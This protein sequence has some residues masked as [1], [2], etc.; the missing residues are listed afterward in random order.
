MISLLQEF[1]QCSKQFHAPQHRPILQWSFENR[2]ADFTTLEFRATVAFLLD[3]LP[4]HVCGTWHLSKKAAQRDAADRALGFFVGCWGEQ[5]VGQQFVFNNVHDP[6]SVAGAK[7]A[8]AVPEVVMLEDY[9]RGLPACQG[10][11]LHWGLIWENDL[12]RAQVEVHLLGVPHKLAGAFRETREAAQRDAARRVLWYLQCP[13]F[14]DLFEPDP[15]A[16]AVTEREIPAPPTHWV[17]DESDEDT[18][19]VAERK[20]ALMRAQNRLQQA[21]A[22]QLK[23]GQSV[24]EWTYETDSEDAGWP[25]MCRATAHVPVIGKT[26]TGDWARGQRAA[27]IDA[28]V[29]VAAFL[30]E[31]GA[32]LA[33]DETTGSATSN[34]LLGFCDPTYPDSGAAK[35]ASVMCPR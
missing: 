5:E 15:H 32:K 17:G 19:Q 16:P 1:V 14:E 3:G 18:L 6:E 12:C 29:H 20:T 33:S 21:F 31:G 28:C 27:Q 24:W 23:P 34:K 2:M 13:G 9:C 4:H 8:A 10:M 30:D 11:G 7:S 35:S 25:P 26:F 22:R